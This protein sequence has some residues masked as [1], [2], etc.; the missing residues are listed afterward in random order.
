MLA[1]LLFPL[2]TAIGE[3]GHLQG[4]VT[5]ITQMLLPPAVKTGKGSGGTAESGGAAAGVAH[6][7]EGD[8]SILSPGGDGNVR[9][10]HM[11]CVRRTGLDNRTR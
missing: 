11:T 9:M 5:S 2:A 6:A 10:T 7:G 3:E 4:S 8:G 1:W